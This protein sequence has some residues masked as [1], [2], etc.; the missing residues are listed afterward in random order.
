METG[1]N[2]AQSILLR[3]LP[4]DL[5]ARLD[6]TL[7]VGNVAQRQLRMR[8]VWSGQGFP[9]DVKRAL[10]IVE[11]DDGAITVVVAR[12]MSDG[13]KK[14][15]I[16]H[17]VAWADASG[18]AEIAVP[19]WF[20]LA[21]LRPANVIAAQPREF[22]WSPS[23]A[24]VGEYI[25]SRRL[26]IPQLREGVWDTVDRV[27]SISEATNISY[28]Q[29]A[30]TLSALDS[31]GYTAKVGPERGPNSSREIK[32]RGRLL[33]DWA[34]SY[35]RAGRRGRQAELHVPWRDTF[36]STDLIERTLRSDRWAVSGWAAAD[37][38]AP[39]TTSLPDL[40]VYV[41]DSD[42]D[43]SLEAIKSDPNVT[44]V[45]RGGRIRFCS[46]ESFAFQ[47]VKRINGRPVV[48][49]IRVYADL[50]RLAGRGAEAADHLREAAIGF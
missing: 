28:G 41:P 16:D 37:A 43:T 44:P 17:H 34:G 20:Y 1:N 26:E 21:R 39:F 6:G 42:F 24:I 38:I 47:F 49:P 48:S 32:D 19:D 27:G 2:L 31:E 15:L 10:S 33:S 40:L 29:V 18:Y 30:K 22:K 8:P 3:V 36:E 23:I 12:K 7:V 4:D 5:Q 46:T 45:E 11:P 13:A 9:A 50:V 14:Y 25:L 35:S